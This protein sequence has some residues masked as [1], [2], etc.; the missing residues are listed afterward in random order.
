MIN[1]HLEHTWYGFKTYKPFPIV[2]VSFDLI[3]WKLWF[4]NMNVVIGWKTTAKTL[5]T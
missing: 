4:V 5:T 1:N 3:E 2:F